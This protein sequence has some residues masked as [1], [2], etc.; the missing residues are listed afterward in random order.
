MR[1]RPLTRDELREIDRRAA[2]EFGVPGIVLM[3]NA[4]RGAARWLTE[5]GIAGPVAVC[6]GKGNNG[7]DGFVIARH[8]DSWGFDVRVLL[9]CESSALGGDALTNLRI[10]EASG[11]RVA[12]W[13]PGRAVNEQ[14]REWLGAADWIVDGLLGT[15]AQG[16]VREPLRSAIESLNACAA[17][18]FAIDIPSGLD[19]DTGEPLGV[20]IRA[21]HTA[22]F[23]SAKIGFQNP[24]AATFTGIVRVFDIGVPRRLLAEFAE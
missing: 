1:L 16:D 11:I 12:R 15:G 21:S 17:R 4:G 13:D 24:T 7:G 14:V 9:A 10:I 5:L 8:L 22:T 23:A 18:R 19:C 3:E 2:D 20:A 6:C